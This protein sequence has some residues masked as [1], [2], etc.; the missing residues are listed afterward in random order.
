ML[1]R[2]QNNTFSSLHTSDSYPYSPLSESVGL[3]RTRRITHGCE[4]WEMQG[5][6]TYNTRTH[7]MLSGAL[8]LLSCTT[9]NNH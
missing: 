2:E 4:Q 8:D 1:Q 5:Y 6:F 7:P 3:I 9:G